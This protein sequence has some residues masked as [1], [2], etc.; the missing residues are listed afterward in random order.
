MVFQQQCQQEQLNFLQA[1]GKLS[2]SSDL[3]LSSPRAPKCILCI[4]VLHI[5]AWLITCILNLVCA[6]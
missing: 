4:G 5:G 1:T 6:Y 2:V 3:W